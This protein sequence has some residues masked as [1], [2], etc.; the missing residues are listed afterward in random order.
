MAPDFPL[1]LSYNQ[2]RFSPEPNMKANQD[3]PGE[4]E[5]RIET[6]FG[7]LDLLRPVWDDAVIRLG[8]TIYMSY[9]WT[10]TWWNFYGEKNELRVFLFRSRE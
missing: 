10:R 8:G 3:L 2:A 9:D 1:T 7:G 6:D 4:L 5:C